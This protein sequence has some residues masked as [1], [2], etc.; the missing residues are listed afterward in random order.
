MMNQSYTVHP[1]TKGLIEQQQQKVNI[2]SSLLKIQIFWHSYYISK[3]ILIKGKVLLLIMYASHYNQ[4]RL[5][6]KF[7]CLLNSA[8]L[9][10]PLCK[11]ESQRFEVVPISNKV[12]MLVVKTA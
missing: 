12:T 3:N 5:S 8:N 1:C 4:F 11:I 9:N 6:K 7:S 2:L 10:I